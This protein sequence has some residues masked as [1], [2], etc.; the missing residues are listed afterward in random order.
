[1]P[2]VA[3]PAAR[4]AWPL[5]RVRT[6]PRA[7]ARCDAHWTAAARLLPQ[8]DALRSHPGSLSAVGSGGTKKAQP[9]RGLAPPW[10]TSTRRGNRGDE[11][12]RSAKAVPWRASGWGPSL[13]PQ[14]R[15]DRGPGGARA[16]EGRPAGFAAGCGV[17]RRRPART[18]LSIPRAADRRPPPRRK[19]RLSL[20]I[21]H[22][23]NPFRTRITRPISR[24]E[25]RPLWFPMNQRACRGVGFLFPCPSRLLGNAAGSCPACSCRPAVRVA[26]PRPGWGV[27]SATVWRG[28][29]W[30]GVLRGGSAQWVRCRDSSMT[31][32]RTAASA[33]YPTSSPRS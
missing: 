25:L 4:G 29:R 18:C 30:R 2:A 19:A 32:S 22:V 26:D 24:R 3:P 23:P 17:C 31:F 8:G 16:R 27:A 10:P 12:P 7:R 28:P 9:E 14:Q 33:W 15:Q 5:P 13:G 11:A 21:H 20:R 1:M 6:P